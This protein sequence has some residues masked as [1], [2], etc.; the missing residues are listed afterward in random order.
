[1]KDDPDECHFIC[2]SSMKTRVMVE[3]QQ[4]NNNFCE[5]LLGVFFHNKLTF[6]ITHRQD[7]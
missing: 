7:L 2:S 1:M 4:I 6:S 5:K 3:N